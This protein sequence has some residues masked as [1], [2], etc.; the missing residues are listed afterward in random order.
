MS[1]NLFYTSITDLLILSILENHDSYMYEMV[2]AISEF[3]GGLLNISQNTI[4]TAAYKLENEGKISEYSK[5]VGRKRTRV[6]YRLEAKGKEYLDDV[7]KTYR[8]TTAG[9]ENVL[10]TLA[11]MEKV[12]SPVKEVAEANENNMQEVSVGA[13]DYV[14]DHE[15]TGETVFKKHCFGY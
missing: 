10:G 13:K 5:L 14:S 7:M 2:K 15:K 8:T 12:P 3:S 6:Y 4:Y 11:G 1:K 9:I